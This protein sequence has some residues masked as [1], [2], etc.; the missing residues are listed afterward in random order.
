[1]RL[2][3]RRD[4]HRARHRAHPWLCAAFGAHRRQ[5]WVDVTRCTLYIL[6]PFAFRMRCSWSGK[7]FRR[8]SAPMS[9]QSRSRARNRRLRWDR[10]R[11]QIAI[12]DARHRWRRL[13][14][15]QCRTFVEESDRA[16]ELRADHLDL[17]R[18]A[19]LT[20]VFGR[21]VGQS[22]TRLGRPRRDG[23]LSSPASSWRLRTASAV[24]THQIGWSHRRQYGRQGTALWRRRLLAVCRH[25]YRCFVRRGQRHARFIHRA[26]RHDSADQ[27]S[28]RRDDRR[29]RRFRHVRHAAVRHHFE[30]SSPA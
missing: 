10:Y 6:L 23:F 5:F 25:H 11:S 14:Q 28:A 21:M 22:A 16:V 18:G 3:V 9:T 1:M 8:R 13:L 4:R 15:R 24:T 27:H 26:R 30:S 20:N 7:V 17:A 29:R 12:E 2:S 19:A